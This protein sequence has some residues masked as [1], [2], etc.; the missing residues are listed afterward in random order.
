M[1][2][3]TT[4]LT[5]RL[6]LRKLLLLLLARGISCTLSLS[7]LLSLH[8]QAL[9]MLNLLRSSGNL[10]Q[11]RMR[12]P[13]PGRSNLTGRCRRRVAR[14]RTTV[15]HHARRRGYVTGRHLMHG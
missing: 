9:E 4:L 8:L 15:V 12:F 6:C 3:G 1:N 14:R 7:N 2:G 13:A 10:C 5:G 11:G